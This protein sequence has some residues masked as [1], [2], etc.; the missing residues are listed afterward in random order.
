MFPLLLDVQQR[1]QESH[2][3][4]V[5]KRRA[6]EGRV[7]NVGDIVSVYDNLTKVNSLGIIHEIKSRNSY[8]V[9]IDTN[10]KHISGDNLRIVQKV[11]TNNDDNSA[12][13]ENIND[14]HEPNSSVNNVINK[15]IDNEQDLSLND[16]S[17]L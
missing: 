4:K 2:R 6:T 5:P 3:N 12:N 10:L 8:I 17:H 9:K 16:E 15:I 11:D 1:L 14:N 7:F 13:S